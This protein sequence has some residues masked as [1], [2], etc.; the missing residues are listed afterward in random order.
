MNHVTPWTALSPNLGGGLVAAGPIRLLALALAI[1]LGFWVS[2]RWLERP[3]LLVWSCALALA[4]RSYTESVDTPVLRLGCVGCGGGRGCRASLLRF[5]IAVALGIATM[6]VAQ[7]NMAWLPWWLLQ[8]AGL[9]ALLVISAAPKPLKVV[10][11]KA[12]S[13]TTEKIENGTAPGSPK[14]GV[15]RKTQASVAAKTR[16]APAQAQSATAVIRARTKAAKRKAN[17]G[18]TKANPAQKGTTQA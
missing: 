1:G 15:R 14:P 6:V 4:L 16:S 12:E 13:R 9:T 3:D 2:R 18:S 11:V 5:E 7:V 8:I 17:P 10:G